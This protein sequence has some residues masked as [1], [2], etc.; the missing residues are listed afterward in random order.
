MKAR[1][2]FLSILEF[3]LRSGR[4]IATSLV[5]LVIRRFFG[6]KLILDL[7][8]SFLLML[9]TI[10]YAWKYIAFNIPPFEDAAILMR[11]ADHF[12]KGY[13]IVW[14]IGEPPVDGATDFLF[15][16]TVGLL[17]RLGIPLSRAVRGLGFISHL[18][19]VLL[20][21]WVNRRVWK[22]NMAVSTF[23]ALYLAFGPGLAY[24]AA[25]F[26]TPFFAFFAA[27]TW[28]FA[29][30]L[31]QH[32]HPPFKLALLFAL[33]GLVTGLIRPEGVI[34]AFL[35]LLSVLWQRGWRH[36]WPLLLAF[37]FVFLL[38]GGAYFL[39]RWDYFGHPFPNPFYKK[40][41]GVLHWDSFHASLR[42]AFRL[43]APFAFAYLLGLRSRKTFFQTL[44]F[45]LPVV[46]FASSFVLIS[47]EMNYGARFQYAIVPIVLL[48]W[49][50]L[51]K[52]LKQELHFSVP[53]SPYWYRIVLTFTVFGIAGGLL[54]YSH[55]QNCF[56][57][58]F[59]KSCAAGYEADGRFDLG[60]ML[61]EYKEKGYVMAI[62]EAGLL[63]FYS[64]W[65]AI[66]TWGL[67]D[68]WIVQNG[69]V[70]EEYLDRYRPHL[71]VFHAYFSPLVP[72]KINEK[73]MA[74][75]WFRMTIILK[76][77]A[78]KRGYI[79]AA[80]FGDSP[81]DTHY[82][83]VRPDFPDS[84]RIVR[85]ISEMKYYYFTTGKRAINYATFSVTP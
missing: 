41:G 80:V 10:G 45:L 3:V 65:T 39:W 62:S 78:E 1:R 58:S 17:A 5:S 34:L 35:M 51:V 24:V 26:G 79:L 49:V 12:A 74:Q 8:V 25:F 59:Q 43:S 63:P 66:D 84:R 40:G 20:V 73:N 21:Y 42:N 44:V 48:S 82:Y 47:D 67:N 4:Q 83:Y 60:I 7:F 68:P 30:L 55:Y 81:Y 71:I 76:E 54:Y 36:S 27:L 33:S 2:I 61:S 85:Q 22:T 72:P 46:G 77:Y 32:E 64:H 29:L 16:I 23:S 69:G 19:S 50:T 75:D 9:L 6:N 57:T 56:L 18:A 13:G 15:M 37:V 11:Y 31:I 14:N 53:A 70:T 52:G 28:S 38:L